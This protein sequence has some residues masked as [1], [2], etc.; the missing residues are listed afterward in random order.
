MELQPSQFFKIAPANPS[1]PNARYRP[2]QLVMG[3]INKW[4][5]DGLAEVEIGG[6]T[7]TAQVDPSLKAGQRYP[8]QVQKEEPNGLLLL[9]V[10]STEGDQG[11]ALNQILKQ[12]GVPMNPRN[13][14]LLGQMVEKGWPLVTSFVKSSVELT[15]NVPQVRDALRILEEMVNR[16]LPLNPEVFKAIQAVKLGPNSVSLLNELE[17]LLLQQEPQTEMKTPSR[18]KGGPQ[19]N[20]EHVTQSESDQGAKGNTNNP[21]LKSVRGSD[22]SPEAEPA[23][24][25]E[26]NPNVDQASIRKAKNT[27]KTFIESLAAP[28]SSS[29]GTPAVPPLPQLIEKMGFFHEAMV[30]RM[31]QDLQEAGPGIVN[32]ENKQVD[33]LKGQL[34]TFLQTM[35][36]SGQI[37]DQ[38]PAQQLLHH[39]TGQQLLSLTHDPEWLS[40]NVQVPIYQDGQRTEVRVK[41]EIKKTPDGQFDAHFCR[42]VFHLNLSQLHETVLQMVVQERA[43]TCSLYTEKGHGLQVI[44]PEA[45]EEM[46]AR[47]KQM[48]YELV[49][50]HHRSE[51]VKEMTQ[52][53]FYQTPQMDVRL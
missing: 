46:K 42:L 10:L 49:G 33:T 1:S 22:I 21:N 38:H 18:S 34:L 15:Q 31:G 12:S 32:S 6:R 3:A 50:F 19:T 16:N 41:W 40:L 52:K 48:D 44:P 2:G 30:E 36:V 53:L 39:L 45:F 17:S 23:Q 43:M 24:Q 20:S 28:P 51:D 9:K 37:L 4:L 14:E 29:K 26:D 11:H 35:S 7:L 5:G 27:L 8:F 13:R 47:L 25:T